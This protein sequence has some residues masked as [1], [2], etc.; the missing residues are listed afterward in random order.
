VRIAFVAT[1]GFDAS[2]RVRVIPAL[3]SYIERLAQRHQ[4]SVYVLRYH[5]RP[6]SYTLRG[7]TI[8]DLGRPA[9]LRR[10]YGALVHA[11]KR[12]GPFDVLHAYWVLPAGFAATLAGRR[13]AIPTVVTADSGEFVAFPD[14]DYGLQQ[15]WQHRLAVRATT[16]L[17]SRVTV[18]TGYMQ[19]LA[20][21]HGCS[22]DVIPIGVDAGIFRAGDHEPRPGP[23][24]R[25]LHV[26]SLNRVKDQ[27]LL[28]H[29]VRQVVDRLMPAAVSLDIVGEDTLGGT[30]QDLASDLRLDEHV[31][32]HGALETEALLPLYQQAHALVVS[33]RHEAASIVALEAAAS[34]V[35]VVGMPVGYLADWTPHAA[36]TARASTPEALADT[37]IDLLH[38]S[39]RRSSVATTAH[40]WVTAHDVDH[41]VAQFEGL[42]QQV[43]TRLAR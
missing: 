29:A 16:A 19:Q 38:D 43:M 2:G 31:T 27:P 23:P 25:L 15:R 24:W 32:F 1:G 17:A 9:G 37:I 5:P 6:C 34:G 4:V 22:P 26:A 11:L 10:Q 41:T 36:V 7:A 30:V 35:P 40:G 14:I 13:L 21:Q 28:L 3:L 8:H 42:Y 12:N 18:C 20:R 33:S 39:E